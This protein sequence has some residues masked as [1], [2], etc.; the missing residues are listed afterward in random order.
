ME[1]VR[2]GVSHCMVCQPGDGEAERQRGGG[3]GVRSSGVFVEAHV[4]YIVYVE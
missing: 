1:S 4:E 2:V 3:G